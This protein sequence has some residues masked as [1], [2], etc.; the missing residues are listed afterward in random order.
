MSKPDL[1]NQNSIFLAPA[2]GVYLFQ[3]HALAEAGKTV[4]VKLMVND[5]PRAYIY[6]RDVSGDNNRF[7]MVSQSVMVAMEAGDRFYILLHEGALKGGGTSHTFTSL[8][9]HLIGNGTL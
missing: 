5:Q 7:A 1:F 9:G 3:F 4:K 2:S 6:D 8:N